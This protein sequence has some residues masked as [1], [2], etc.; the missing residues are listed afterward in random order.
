[1]Q[2]K[3]AF[4][5]G[6]VNAFC[7]RDYTALGRVSVQVSDEGLTISSPGSFIEGVTVDNLLTVEPRGRNPLLADI[8]KR[9]G[10]AE[11]TGRG[12][13]RIF[14]GSIVFGRPCPD[15]SESTSTTVRLFIP[16][17]RADIEFHRMI[18][19]YKEKHTLSMTAL[20]ILSTLRTAKRQ[21]FDD[22]V[23]ACHTGQVR[24]K[25]ELESLVE[26]GMVEGIGNAKAREFI[27]SKNF[28][29]ADKNVQGHIRQ[30]GIDVLRHEELILQFAKESGSVSRAEVM[31]L[32]KVNGTQATYLLRKLVQGKKL[33]SEGERRST[34]YKI[35]S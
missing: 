11:R 6:L 4:R 10:L 29:R 9:I 26:N 8:L 30:T 27:L 34:R 35:V 12:V 13:D 3:R 32:L 7:H 28:Y 17:N 23:A 5:E 31:D 33:M 22:L 20:L 19:A 15:Y 2:H 25:R 18:V 14:E 1:M 16:R 24:V 21:T